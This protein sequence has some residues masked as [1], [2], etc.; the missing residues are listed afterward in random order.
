MDCSPPDSVHGIFQARI[1]KCLPF[2]P[3]GDLP[4][5]GIEPASLHLQYCRWILYTS[6]TW[7][8]QG[9][10]NSLTCTYCLP[11]ERTR[12]ERRGGHAWKFLSS[13][14]E[15]QGRITT[16][17]QSSKWSQVHSFIQPPLSG[18][19][20]TACWALSCA[21]EAW[22]N[23]RTA[24]C[25]FTQSSEHTCPFIPQHQTMSSFPCPFIYHHILAPRAEPGTWVMFYM[26]IGWIYGNGNL[27]WTL[28]K[29]HETL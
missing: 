1:L 22:L 13:S 2:P 3:L 28:W 27:A 6:A 15:I 12:T 16:S 10:P 21:P 20:P 9:N 7:E 8:T 11:I 24:C 26:L 23:Q 25:C 5:P 14:H 29:L 19:L 18:C 17:C 4:N